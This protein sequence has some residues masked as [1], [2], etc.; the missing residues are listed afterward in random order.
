MTGTSSTDL[1]HEC[2]HMRPLEA[3]NEGANT[4]LNS[5]IAEYINDRCKVSLVVWD[6][7]CG[8]RVSG[9]APAKR[10]RLG[11]F[12]DVAC[13]AWQPSLRF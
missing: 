5:R 4:T 11:K 2:H 8:N 6:C 12:G 1:P 13:V 9:V 7:A 3:N 10:T